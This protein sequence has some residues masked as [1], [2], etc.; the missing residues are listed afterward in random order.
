MPALTAFI[1]ANATQYKTVMG[2]VAAISERAAAATLASFRTVETQLKAQ[3]ALVS[4]ATVE[5]EMYAASLAS[6]QA[7]MAKIEVATATNTATMLGQST[8]FAATPNLTAEEKYVADYKRLL[9]ERDMAAKALKAEQLSTLVNIASAGGVASAFGHGGGPGGGIS[10]IMRETLVIFRELGR[11]NLTRVPGSVTLLAQYMGILGKLV[12]STAQESIIAAAAEN[13]LAGSM[14]AAALAAEEKATATAAAARI[15]VVDVEASNALAAA[16][17]REAVALRMAAIAQ[18][19][20]AR[21]AQ[22]AAEIATAGARVSIGPLGYLTAGLI[23][24]G[25][26]AF[27]TWRHF[28]N[29][30][31]QTKNLM[32]LMNPFKKSYQDEAEALKEQNNA[33]QEFQDWLQKELDTRLKITETIDRH[34]KLMQDEYDAQRKI[35]ELRGATAIQLEKMDENQMRRQLEYLRTMLQVAKA[36]R[37][38]AFARAAEASQGFNPNPMNDQGVTLK[39]A[40]EMAKNAGEIADSVIAASQRNQIIEKLQYYKLVHGNVPFLPNENESTNPFGL[41]GTQMRTGFEDVQNKTGRF[42]STTTIDEVIAALNDASKS[43]VVTGAKVGTKK[44][45]G[46]TVDEAIAAADKANSMATALEQIVQAEKD[47]MEST[48]GTAQERQQGVEKLQEQFDELAA[49]LGV[50]TK[51]GPTEAALEGHGRA[52]VTERERIGVGAPN[53]ALLSVAQQQLSATRETNRILGQIKGIPIG[54][55]SATIAR[56]DIRPFND[57]FGG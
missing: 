51:Y 46:M 25:A 32:D 28:H 39:G 15:E 13:K 57:M 1:G 20:K 8:I 45:P 43:E 11:G 50:K 33:R 52:E 12:K 37:D 40:Q 56:A 26:A 24:V 54:A 9:D 7:A 19:E 34:L 47:L 35:A 23:A 31:I 30:A 3:M 27:F 36:D 21:A 55:T 22:T 5:W 29:L 42:K 4:T 38:A 53:V 10:G 6:V 14:A 44:L 2:E 48:K 18:A 16:S 49:A 41:S 17:E